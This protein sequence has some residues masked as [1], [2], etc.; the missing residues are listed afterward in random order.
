MP[1]AAVARA[2]SFRRKKFLAAVFLY[3]I[4]IDFMA[5]KF[6]VSKKNIY[7][8]FAAAT[9][10]RAEVQKVM[11][12]FWS[13]KFGN[14]SSLHAQGREAGAALTLA[15]LQIAEQLHAKSNEII[16]TAG[17]TESVNLA[18]L[19]A[20][21]KEA[22]LR[23][24]KLHLLATSFEHECVNKVFSSL[25]GEGHNT[26]FLAVD[27]DGLVDLGMLKKS[28]RPDTFFISI[29]YANN[30]IGTIQ[31][32]AEIGQWLKKVNQE[33][34][35]QGLT[36]ILLHADACQAAGFLDLN[37]DR[38]GVDLMSV[39][40]SKIYGPKGTGFLYVRQGTELE[41][42][43]FGGGQER[44]LRGGTENVPGIVG[45]AKALVLAQNEK[46][47]ESLRLLKLQNYF[48]GQIR[49]KISNIL[50]NGPDNKDLKVNKRLPNNINFVFKGVEGEALMLYLDSYN[51]SVSTSSACSTNSNEA[52]HVLL[53]IGRSK[54]DALSSVR[55]S[56]GRTT[57]KADLDYVVKVLILMVDQQRRVHGLN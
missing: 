21:R 20:V 7:L 57:T 17:G 9:P 38:L 11:A 41:P 10:L 47:K 50:L 24:R 49:D 55:F 53:A 35:Q 16:F 2:C 4:E 37:V 56:M 19:G 34:R 31:P 28:I 18:I 43:I 8:D 52:S 42:V 48:I 12:P 26:E 6:P 22:A 23:K 45:L 29:I 14:P 25:A 15:R 40:G 3:N 32:L 54:K 51:I 5:K 13:A 36:R 44:N 1:T 46:S 30:E 39:N 33:R 27:K